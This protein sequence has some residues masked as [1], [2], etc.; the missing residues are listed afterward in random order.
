MEV[1]VTRS[2]EF[3]TAKIDWLQIVFH[4]YEIEEILTTALQID[5]ACF[6]IENGRVKHKP[7]DI[8]YTY[9]SI[10]VFTE[11][12]PKIGN[13][14]CYLVLS[15]EGCTVYE[16]LLQAMEL[17][18]RDFFQRLFCY[19]DGF[20]EVKRLD[21]ALD[22]RNEQP[23]FTLKQ[24]IA[25]TEKKEFYSRNRKPD[26]FQ[27]TA[28]GNKKSFTL[29]IGRRKSDVMFRIYDK[30]L[31]T[32]KQKH[33]AVEE[34][35]SW[36]RLEIELKRQVAHAMAKVI[37]FDEQ[38]LEELIR[39]VVKDEL[40]FYTDDTWGKVWRP[41]ERYLG[42]IQP[43]HLSRVYEVTGLTNTQDWL[44]HG[45]GLSGIKAFRFL[46]EHEAL[47]HLEQLDKLVAET[48]YTR[49]LAKKIADHLIDIGRE[50]LIELVYDQTKKE[51]LEKKSN[52]TPSL[53]ST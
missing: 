12:T 42:N 36:K 38:S 40:T 8:C 23:Y 3:V 27:S 9:G 7:Y 5:L 49:S 10:K 48:K 15:G 20:F 31:E 14:E 46:A 50:D 29:Y 1:K 28:V 41:W 13:L 33:C 2:R 51:N 37:A 6:L 24:L 34:I 45:G 53:S 18:W 11:E 47:G 52:E 21:V 19:F 25:K 43:L 17:T 22:D 39:G 30:D 32:A 26:V 4:G 16:R 44:I 35:G